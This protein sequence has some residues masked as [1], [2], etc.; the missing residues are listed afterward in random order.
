MLFRHDVSRA[1]GPV[2]SQ[3]SHGVDA[4]S[5][6]SQTPHR[7]AASLPSARG[8]RGPPAQAARGATC[9]VPWCARRGDR[10]R[11]HDVWR[12]RAWRAPRHAPRGCTP[13]AADSC[14]PWEG[15]SRLWLPNATAV[16]TRRGERCPCARSRRAGRRACRAGDGGGAQRVSSCAAPTLTAHDARG[17]PRSLA[18]ARLVIALRSALA[19][20]VYACPSSVSTTYAPPESVPCTRQAEEVRAPAYSGQAQS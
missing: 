10:R 7:G 3:P 11:S 4:V 5:A 19:V 20:K 8:L 15:A 16:H 14:P 18:A 17:L 1:E 12:R 13:P 6:A 9:A 2:G